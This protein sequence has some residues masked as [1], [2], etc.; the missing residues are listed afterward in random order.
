MTLNP[1]PEAWACVMVTLVPPELVKVSVWLAVPFT[2]TLP[3][4][5]LES[6]LL[7]KPGVATLPVSGTLRLELEALLAMARFPLAA[8]LDWGVKVTLKVVLWPAASATGRVRPVM[9]KPAPDRLA[10]VMVR[11]EPPVLVSVS[12]RV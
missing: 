10:W 2:G 4:L 7:S 1:V 12:E 5:R 8:P 11:L 3:K 9:V 6:L